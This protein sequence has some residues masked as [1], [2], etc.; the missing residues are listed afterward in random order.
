MERNDVDELVWVIQRRAFAISDGKHELVTLAAVNA[1][2][3]ATTITFCKCVLDHV[4]IAL[5]IIFCKYVLDCV[6]I[7]LT[8]AYGRD[9]CF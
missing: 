6:F 4:F 8:I 3:L 9:I 5:T 7:A 2:T 1:H